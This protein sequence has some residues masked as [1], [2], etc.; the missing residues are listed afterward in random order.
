MTESNLLH[1]TA[2]SSKG[3]IIKAQSGFYT[4]ETSQGRYTCRLRGKLKQN[5]LTGDIV[6]VGDWVDISP[7]PDGTGSI[8]SVHP[9]KSLLS[10]Q[11]SGIKTNYQQILLAN[12]DQVVLIFA[13]TK[14]E[15][16]LRMLDRFLVIA[17]RQEIPVI[18]VANKFDLVNKHQA[19]S[20]FGIYTRLGYRV[21]FTSAKTGKGVNELH[22][23]LIGRISA[24]TGP[25]GVGKSS[26]LNAIQPELGLQV[27]T[28]SIGT[29]KGKHTTQVR[30]LFPLEKGGYVADMPGVRTL[31]LWDIEPEELDAYFCELRD[32]VSHCQFSDCT[33][34][35]EPGCAVMAAV[36][37]GKID[38]GRYESYLRLR[39][40]GLE[41]DVASLEEDMEEE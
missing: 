13:C 24:F 2:S 15:P 7:L 10:R 21:I 20:I 25:S 29:S 39:F 11:L 8:D 14:P 27:R 19:D 33:H 40:G 28:V 34:S 35:H 12:P 3:L 26:L 4:V 6:A 23:A 38:S 31:A 32:L 22:R 36:E 16:R 9:R 41:E 17:E 5:R 1:E 30:E 18:I 37:N